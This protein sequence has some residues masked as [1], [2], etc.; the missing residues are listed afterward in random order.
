MP[1][2]HDMFR[3]AKIRDQV[4]SALGKGTVWALAEGEVGGSNETATTTQIRISQAMAAI[5]IWDKRYR[6]SR[7]ACNSPP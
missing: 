6:R 7:T 5:A 2:N 4:N 1:R 3:Q